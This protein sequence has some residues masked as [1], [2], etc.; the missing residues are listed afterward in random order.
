MIYKYI[1]EGY[2][3]KYKKQPEKLDT[4]GE[5]LKLDRRTKAKVSHEC[6]ECHKVFNRSAALVQHTRIHTK[7]RPLKW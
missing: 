4:P 5:I 6:K 2:D 1:K 7:E 3:E